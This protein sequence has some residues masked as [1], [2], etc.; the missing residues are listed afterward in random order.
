[1]PLAFRYPGADFSGMDGTHDLYIGSVVHQAFVEVDE[2]G[3]E[4]AAATA[5][6]MAAGSA[7]R[8]TSRWCFGASTMRFSS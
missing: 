6:M 1:M 4:A 5:V 2:K 7:S 8:S 3:T